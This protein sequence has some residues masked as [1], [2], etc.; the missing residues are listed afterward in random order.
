MPKGA[1]LKLFISAAS[2]RTGSLQDLGVG[3]LLGEGQGGF[4]VG[5]SE[6]LQSYREGTSVPC[7][8]LVNNYSI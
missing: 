7:P 8:G 4:V 1:F 3:L 6:S 5:R 2:P